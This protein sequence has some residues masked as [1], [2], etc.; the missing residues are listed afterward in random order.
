MMLRFLCMVKH[1]FSPP[2]GRICLVHL[3]QASNRSQIQDSNLTFL[4]RFFLRLTTSL[5]DVVLLLCQ[6]YD[7][8]QSLFV[9]RQSDDQALGKKGRS[10]K[11]TNHGN[12]QVPRTPQF[13]PPH[14]KTRPC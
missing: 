8:V 14:K 9:G 11:A 3:F 10:G 5:D 1:H 12:L 13:H 7:E 6:V 2:F 4:P